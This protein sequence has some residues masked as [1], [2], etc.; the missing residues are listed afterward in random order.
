MRVEGIFE[1]CCVD[2]L[3]RG[4]DRARTD[5]RM[6]IGGDSGHPIASLH[7]AAGTGSGGTAAARLGNRV[8]LALPHVATEAGNRMSKALREERS[9]RS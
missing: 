3:S 9:Q 8:G 1:Q 6:S 4:E 5:D 7:S 2:R